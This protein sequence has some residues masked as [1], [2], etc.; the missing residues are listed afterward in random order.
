MAKNIEIKARVNNFDRLKK[1]VER[2]SDAPAEILQ[3]EDTFFNT[4]KGRLKLRIFAAARGELIFYQREDRQGPK[5]SFYLISR[6]DAPEALRAALEGA[7]GIRGIVKKTRL[8]YHIGQ[9]R[10]HLDEVAGLGQFIELEVVLHH[11]QSEEEGEKIAHDLM[12][13]L[14]IHERDLISNAYVDMLKKDDFPH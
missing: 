10:V 3:Q 5:S 7:L 11:D 12:Q 2:L 13:Q 8:V 1:N 9:T 6:T 4:Q 14:G